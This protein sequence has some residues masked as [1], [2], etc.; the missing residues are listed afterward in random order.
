MQSF[1]RKFLH[2]IFKHPVSTCLFASTW[3]TV[4]YKRCWGWCTWFKCLLFLGLLKKKTQKE[5]STTVHDRDV[6]TGVNE[7]HSNGLYLFHF[8]KFQTSWRLILQCGTMDAITNWGP[9]CWE[10]GTVKGSPFNK[11]WSRSRDSHA[12]FTHS[13]KILPN[14][15]LPGPFNFIYSKSILHFSLC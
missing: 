5:N 14:F 4:D 15:Y 11:A 12:C 9:L 8:S 2:H 7:A 1:I 6:G 3:T 10:L 13:Q